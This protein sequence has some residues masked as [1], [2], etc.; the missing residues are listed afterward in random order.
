LRDG[1]VRGSP[2][3]SDASADEQQLFERISRRKTEV[4]WLKKSPCRE[5]RRGRGVTIAGRCVVLFRTR[6]QKDWELGVELEVA[7]SSELVDTGEE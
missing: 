2:Q 3:R 1:A 5:A 7:F 4:E 6:H